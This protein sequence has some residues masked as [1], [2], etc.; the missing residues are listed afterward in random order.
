[1]CADIL[2]HF[3]SA[4]SMTTRLSGGTLRGGV[5]TEN[6][7]KGARTVVISHSIRLPDKLV[8][9]G[10]IVLIFSD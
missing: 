7:E 10:I 8:M 1:M 9:A 3:D 4:M 5:K 2:R 6:R